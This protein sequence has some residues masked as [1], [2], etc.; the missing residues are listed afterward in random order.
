MLP[1]LT[2]ARTLAS[3]PRS[4]G[5]RSESNASWLSFAPRLRKRSPEKT[6][7]LVRR[8]ADITNQEPTLPSATQLLRRSKKAGPDGS[9]FFI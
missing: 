6:Y 1:R 8:K 5:R 9:G 4:F 7:R 2:S 3:T